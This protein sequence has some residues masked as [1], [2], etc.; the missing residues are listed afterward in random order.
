MIYLSINQIF[1]RFLKASIRLFRHRLGWYLVLLVMVI[2]G[3]ATKPPELHTN[4][5]TSMIRFLGSDE[6]DI[7]TQE[8]IVPTITV[9]LKAGIAFAPS[10]DYGK[11]F[12]EKERM[13]LMEK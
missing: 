5:K 11:G 13:N 1:G 2:T 6:I 7:K 10:N 12:P 4:Y 9:P 3:C 8:N